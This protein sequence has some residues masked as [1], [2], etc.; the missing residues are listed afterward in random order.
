MDPAPDTAPSARMD[1]PVQPSRLSTAPVYN[2][3]DFVAVRT[4]SAAFWLAKLRQN[5]RE[6]A[7]PT[8]IIRVQWLEKNA[9][10]ISYHLDRQDTMVAGSIICKVNLSRYQATLW[11]D[12]TAQ[13]HLQSCLDAQPWATSGLESPSIEESSQSEEALDCPI[14][15]NSSEFWGSGG[16]EDLSVA[17]LSP[18]QHKFHAECVQVLLLYCH[19]LPAPLICSFRTLFNDIFTCTCIWFQF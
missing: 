7:S 1:L 6:G 10:K 15:L 5:V 14:C 12:K 3:G 4:E 9:D 11:L 18:C 2:T 13:A 19:V 8:D 17:E 16:S